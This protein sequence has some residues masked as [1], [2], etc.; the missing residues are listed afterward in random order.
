MTQATPT[1]G[2]NQS[3]LQYRNADNDGKKALLNHHKG[4]TAPSYA[5]AGI[6][7]LDDTAT[8]WI[9]KIY[10]GTDWIVLA[11]VN[12]T[13][14]AIE[15]YHGTAALRLLNHATDTGSANAYAVAPVP[16]ITAYATGQL[17]TLKPANAS[18]GACTLAVS[19]LAAKN[20]KLLDGTDPASGALATTG[21]YVLVYDGTNFI[22]LNSGIVPVSGGGTGASTASAARTNLGLGSVAT[23]TAGTAANNAVQ[24]TAAAKLPAVDGSLLTNL[25]VSNQ[26]VL[27]GTATAS[28]SSSLSFNSMIS[29]T[30]ASYIMVIKGLILSTTAVL[31]LRTSHDNGSTFD[32]T[33]G[34]YDSNTVK[35]AAGVQTVAA[36]TITTGVSLTPSLNYLYLD[37][38]IDFVGGLNETGNSATP[39]TTFFFRSGYGATGNSYFSAMG[40]NTG[41]SGTNTLNSVQLLPS[42]GNF[43]SGTVYFYGVKNT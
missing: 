17:V 31:L 37:G 19:G 22:L 7:W 34:H 1:I 15:A 21:I 35:F 32:S 40:K 24:L 38:Q 26:V 6:I 30:Y 14:N 20:I 18:T 2:A 16:S 28:T 39:D 36:G 41:A 3:G 27:L 11:S 23:L 13:T 42:A 9:L 4:S 43:T 33:S 29:S 10:D 25:P 5:E 12:A 8:P